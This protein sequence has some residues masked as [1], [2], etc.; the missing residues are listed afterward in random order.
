MQVARSFLCLF[1]LLLIAA[2]AFGEVRPGSA[3][4]HI[5]G[6]GFVG[7]DI[8]SPSPVSPEVEIDNGFVVGLRFGG[9]FTPHW[10][11]EVSVGAVP[12]SKLENHPTAGEDGAAFLFAD[13]S[14]VNY[15]NP[16]GTHVAYI[17]WGVG[18]ARSDFDSREFFDHGD[19]FT[20]HFAI[21]GRFLVTENFMLRVEGRYRYIDR[22]AEIQSSG[23]DQEA[24]VFEATFGLGWRWG[25][26]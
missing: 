6:G 8:G 10:G 14:A 11:I 20:A 15:L 2:P 5:F 22:V 23:N 18:A 12:D 16:D 3:E 1:A 9:V 13:L 7:D 24:N 21:G 19:S 4:L 17:A 26:T 25:G